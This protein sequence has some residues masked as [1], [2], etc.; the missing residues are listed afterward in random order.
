MR[1]EGKYS[2]EAPPEDSA[3]AEGQQAGR[4]RHE[5]PGVLVVD[6][7]RFVRIV[8][9]MALERNGFE[10]WLAA[11]GRE[12]IRLYRMHRESIAV[13]LLD[14]R[15]PGLD[16]PATLDALRDL[17]PDVQ[18]CF[19]S[20]D[21][22]VYDPEALRKHGAARVIAKPFRLDDLANAL[23]SLIRGEPTDALRSGK[24]CQG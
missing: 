20:S 7:K 24:A 13:V 17:N 9:Q 6:D 8:L 14:V 2:I 18:V 12:A 19:M 4:N 1:S 5:K 11:N 3:Q 21:T 16:G 10:A 15:M 22:G 23:L